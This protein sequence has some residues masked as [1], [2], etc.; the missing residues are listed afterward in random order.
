MIGG[1]ARGVH[2]PAARVAPHARGHRGVAGRRADADAAR[3]L[4]ACG[5]AG[6]AVPAA[7]TRRCCT[8][9]R[10]TASC[11]TT[12]GASSSSEHDFLVG[13]S[14]DGPRETPR[15]LPR[16]PARPRHVRQGDGRL[17][18]AAQARRRVQHPVHGERRQRAPRPNGVPLLPRRAGREV[19][20]VHPHRRARHAK[21]RC[22]SPTRAG[23]IDPA[24][25]RL[26]YTQTGNLVTER[27]VGGEQYGRFLID[28]FEEWVRH[29]VGT[30]FV[31]LFDVTLEAFF[32]RH[33]LCIHA[34]DL[35]RTARHSST[36]ATCTAATT[37]S[38]PTT[39]SATSTTRTWSS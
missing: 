9:S 26:L 30:V 24:R 28:V 14:V 20:A 29:D 37:S 38:S 32:G 8:R 7:R 16:R 19:D 12:S 10:P 22:R 33:L 11:S 3:V 25:K 13:L 35:R 36:T 15:H 31:Q 4:P 34:P 17:A 21:P 2:P 6:R 27:S 1:H 39:C 18:A 5:R 23:A